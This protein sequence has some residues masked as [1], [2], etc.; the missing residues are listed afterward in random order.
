M[1]TSNARIAKKK[2]LE[3]LEAELFTAENEFLN[4]HTQIDN[5]FKE[6]KK[7][8]GKINFA[9]IIRLRKNLGD[10]KMVLDKIHRNIDN[11]QKPDNGTSVVLKVE[12]LEA[13]EI[14]IQQFKKENNMDNLDSIFISRIRGFEQIFDHIMNF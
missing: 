8:V 6:G 11:I 2:L 13:E 10:L 7:K 12:T 5:F 3:T 4:S 1:G 14:P 9:E